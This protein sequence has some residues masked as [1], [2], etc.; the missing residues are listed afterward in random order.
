MPDRRSEQIDFAL[1]RHFSAV[2]T[3]AERRQLVDVIRAWDDAHPELDRTARTSG[4][5][6]IARDARQRPD[7]A[8][9]ALA[10]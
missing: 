10:R 7:G 6:A 4:W 5:L 8:W 2:F 3:E 9:L 1:R